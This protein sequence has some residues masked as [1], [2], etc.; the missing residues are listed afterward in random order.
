MRRPNSLSRRVLAALTSAL[1]AALVQ[2]CSGSNTR[3]SPPPPPPIP[4]APK[5]TCPAP[6]TLLSPLA[7]PISVVYGTPTVAAGDPP[8]T[9]ACTPISGSI[10]PVGA[11]Q[12]TCTA[13]DNRQ[14]TDTC[15]FAITVNAPP[16]IGA[17][18]YVAFGDS[19]TA[20]E[21]V[22]E[23]SGYF[24]TLRV[25]PAKAYPAD[26]QRN[27]ADVYTTQAASISV[28]NQGRP[29]E[30]AADAVG[31]FRGVIG[32]AGIE[33]VT[34][35]DGA[36]DLAD[37]DSRTAAN[38]LSA[39]RTM[40]QMAKGRGLHVFLATLP[41]M[42]PNG[43]CPNRGLPASTVPAFNDA[44]R[45]IAN[46][47]AATLVD[48]YEAFNGDITTLVDADGLHPTAAGYQ[49]IADTF[50]KAIKQDLEQ[51]AASSLMSPPGPFSPFRLPQF[52][53]PVRRR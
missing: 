34:L 45:G 44:I 5:L 16:K 8:V 13:T 28:E 32:R 4:D 38:G 20:G 11:T 31:R 51:P 3:P 39:I 14:R 7:S 49:K 22:S 35:M 29:G 9:I 21:I 25:D 2:A 10:F 37:R 41:P 26:L 52:A 1:A 24:R 18:R 36:N 30:A 27:L 6:V 33:A 15:A 23:G 17:T 42:N 53:R 46:A 43:C 19:M 48:V 50:F 47:E 40:V 12:V